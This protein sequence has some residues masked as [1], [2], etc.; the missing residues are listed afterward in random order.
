M[1]EKAM[2][3]T[4][5]NDIPVWYFQIIIPVGFGLITFRFMINAL[6]NIHF[7]ITGGQDS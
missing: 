2:G 3:T 4:I 7:L 6:K 5:F 1:D